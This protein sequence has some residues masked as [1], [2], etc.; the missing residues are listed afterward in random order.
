ML[1]LQEIRQLQS[2]ELE[3][4]I[5]KSLHELLQLKMDIINGHSKENHKVKLLKHYIARLETVSSEEKN[6]LVKKKDLK[7]DIG[8]KASQA[9]AMKKVLKK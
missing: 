7:K 6:K 5:A 4:E 1:S 9:R 8:K 2:S 3:E